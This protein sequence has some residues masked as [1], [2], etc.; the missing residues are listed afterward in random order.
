M[1]LWE[2]NCCVKAFNKRQAEQGKELIS[3][4]WQTASFTGAAFAGKLKKLDTYL[5][6]EGNKKVSPK[7]NKKEFEKRL[8]KAERRAKHVD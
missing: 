7:V 5:K 2:F 1:E 8:A 6:E 3:T 4:S